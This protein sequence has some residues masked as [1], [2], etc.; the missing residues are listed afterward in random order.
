MD[1]ERP[2]IVAASICTY[3]YKVHSTT[4]SEKN[5]LYYTGIIGFIIGDWKI[6]FSP[7]ICIIMEAASDPR[8]L[9]ADLSNAKGANLD[10]CYQN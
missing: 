5:G 6:M 4:L 10:Y 8:A 3:L 1:V 7:Q 2:K 9:Y